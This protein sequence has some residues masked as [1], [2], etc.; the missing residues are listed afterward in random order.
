[1]RRKSLISSL[2]KVFDQGDTYQKHNIYS[3]TDQIVAKQENPDRCLHEYKIGKF[4]LEN[5][6]FVPKMYD[7][8]TSEELR[9]HCKGSAPY[10][11]HNF[12]VMQKIPG[13]IRMGLCMEERKIADRKLLEEI[14]K[15]LDLGIIPR[16][17]ITST[18]SILNPY[19]DE[20]YLIDLES[21]TEESSRR[22]I[23]EFRGIARS[24]LS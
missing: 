1:M 12:L 16:D 11:Y 23:E 13:E 18:N 22:E 20:L 6:V 8:I 21:W 2:G 17:S 10:K 9:K 14:E 15:I 4:V 7:I 5:G 3:I 24:R 19:D